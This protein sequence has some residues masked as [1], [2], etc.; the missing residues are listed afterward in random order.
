MLRKFILHL[1][2]LF[3]LIHGTNALA[4]E[5]CS[6][7]H[8]GRLNQT[9]DSGQKD[10]WNFNFMFEQQNWDEKPADE[11]HELHEEGHHF[12]DKTHEEFYHFSLGINATDTF[13]LTAEIPYVVRGSIE[14]KDHDRLGEKEQSEGW[15]DLY[16]L[17]TYKLIKKEANYLGI[18][19]GIKFPSGQTNEENSEGIRFEPE[20]QPGTG[21]WD[22]P[23]GIVYQYFNGVSL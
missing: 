4:C 21:S 13:S 6:I 2:T 19:G 11:A 8:V 3:I 16:L 1:L 18:V 23:V 5:S 22:Y 10:V 12:H 15:G 14:V 17:G 9:V 7:Q 20:L